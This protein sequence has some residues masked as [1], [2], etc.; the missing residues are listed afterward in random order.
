MRRPG[1]R[2]GTR[3]AR[4]AGTAVASAER[5]STKPPSAG[6]SSPLAALL[7][8][9]EATVDAAFAKLPAG[10]VENLLKPENRAQLRSILL[11]H[12]V[13]GSLDAESELHQGSLRTL[14]GSRLAATVSDTVKFY[15]ATVI[16]A[17]VIASNGVIHVIDKVLLPP[18]N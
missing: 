9:P 7:P 15:D 6:P 17:D 4:I 3:A 2:A 18:I 13:R 8:A 14:H 16:T 1:P 12:V 5:S 10:T 11:Y